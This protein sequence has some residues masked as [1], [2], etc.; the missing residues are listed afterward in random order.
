MDG[1]NRVLQAGPVSPSA[2][3]ALDRELSLHD[4]MDG[5]NWALRSERAFSLSSAREVPGT[6]L[7]L[8]KGFV[9]EL[10]LGLIGVFDH[11]LEKG[12]RPYAEVV[13]DKRRFTPGGGPNLYGA[14]V[15][16]L[17]PALASLREPAERTRAMSRCLRV[18]NALQTHIS[19][20]GD[21]VPKLSELG[22]PAAA[23]LDPYNGEPLHLKRRADGWVVYSV[24]R[25][26]V[27]DGGALDRSADIGVGPT[28]GGEAKKKP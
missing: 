24:G 6:S 19:S 15:T 5:Y 18:L 22:L 13:A 17:E 28:D 21:L 7:W 1:I 26:L 14:L 20:G 27:D 16:L 23:T 3:Q 2:R 12:A 9:N 4:T 25:D 8:T 10:G 11:F